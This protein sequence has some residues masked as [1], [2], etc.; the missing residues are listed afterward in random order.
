MKK[1]VCDV[2]GWVYDE[3]NGDPDTLV[4]RS[5]DF[6]QVNAQYVRVKLTPVQ[7]IPDWHYASGKRTFVFVDEII[8]K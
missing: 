4:D 8:V 1:Y 2:C 5:Y 6:A 7:S 3:A